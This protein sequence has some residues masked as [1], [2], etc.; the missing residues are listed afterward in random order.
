[1]G[2]HIQMVPG[3]PQ[4]HPRQGLKAI[5]AI[6]SRRN[7]L[8]GP[9]GRDC[10][11]TLVRPAG[12][13]SRTPD[14]GTWAAGWAAGWATGL[15]TPGASDVRLLS[16]RQ[17]EK[18][19]YKAVCTGILHPRCAFAGKRGSHEDHEKRERQK[20]EGR[21]KRDRARE[22]EKREELFCMSALLPFLKKLPKVRKKKCL[23]N[24]P[25]KL[26]SVLVSIHAHTEELSD[27]PLGTIGAGEISKTPCPVMFIC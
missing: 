14:S 19:P 17:E 23:R 21:E 11:E 25:L 9:A 20:K 13:Q 22:N 3:K 24:T 2:M 27:R 26:N 10:H 1:M 12:L 18:A 7:V 4:G 16:F 8:R 15:V 6:Y 5:S